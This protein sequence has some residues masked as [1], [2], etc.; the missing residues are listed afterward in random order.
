MGNAVGNAATHV[1]SKWST[2]PRDGDLINLDGIDLHALDESKTHRK[3][4]KSTR[5]TKEYKNLRTLARQGIDEQRRFQLWMKG[6]NAMY[7]YQLMYDTISRE[8]F[9]GVD[10]EEFPHFPQFGSLCEFNKLLPLKTLHS[11]SVDRTVAINHQYHTPK[12]PLASQSQQSVPISSSPFAPRISAK[13]PSHFPVPKAVATPK[14]LKDGS[15]D[16]HCNKLH[17][18]QRILLVL[19]IE[20]DS[21]KYCPQLPYV[22]ERMLLDPNATE[23]GVFAICHSMLVASKRNNWY[24]RTDYFNSYVRIKTFLSIFEDNVSAVSAFLKEKKMDISNLLGDAISSMFVDFLNEA[25]YLRLVDIFTVEGY[26]ILFRVGVAL[27]NH[28]QQK[29]VECDNLS[30]F[31]ATLVRESNKLT[32]EQLCQRCFAIYL[33]RNKF[34]KLDQFH[35]DK[36]FDDKALNAVEE[37]SYVRRWPT[38]NANTLKQSKILTKKVQFLQLWVWLPPGC[39]IGDYRMLFSTEKDGY[40]LSSLYLKCQEVCNLIIVIKTTR[41]EI[42]GVFVSQLDDPDNADHFAPL[43]RRVVDTKILLF[44]MYKTGNFTPSLKPLKAMKEDKEDEDGDDQIKSDDEYKGDE[45]EDPTYG[46]EPQCFWADTA[47]QFYHQSNF[48][49]KNM[50]TSRDAL[51][52]S[53]VENGF[54]GIE[55]EAKEDDGDGDGDGTE[56]QRR[57]P[58]V[59]PSKEA[60]IIGD[61]VDQCIYLDSDLNHGLSTKCA[62]FKS[63]CLVTD[64]DGAFQVSQVEVWC[65]E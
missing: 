29:L 27:L 34:D 41:K 56:E 7:K 57:I 39:H 36:G 17:E 60:L 64:K 47:D 6:T 26:K 28:A 21:L 59:F 65:V 19:A 9:E 45:D 20:H 58:V 8:L 52:M 25:T 46:F 15:P 10:M 37:E 31:R 14:A 2:S 42:I 49:M 53:E 33:T 44:Q 63:P 4:D 51:V 5:K 61:G 40:K 54:V 55:N 18:A 3:E 48:E 30:L 35:R 12:I 62:T 22:V 38:W 24:F 32:P 23:Q 50:H 43:K 1:K 13:S 16:V 11:L